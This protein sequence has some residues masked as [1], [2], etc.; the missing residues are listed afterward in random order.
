MVEN[1]QE[2]TIILI[3]VFIIIWCRIITIKIVIG[4][5]SHYILLELVLD[6]T[7]SVTHTDDDRV[8]AR[9]CVCDAQRG[10]ACQTNVVERWTV[11]RGIRVENRS[12]NCYRFCTLLS[13][14]VPH[15]GLLHLRSA[16]TSC[17]TPVLHIRSAPV[18]IRFA[19]SFCISAHY[20]FSGL[21][22]V[23]FIL[24][25]I[26]RIANFHLRSEK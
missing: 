2:L 5:S 11:W 12:A 21:F 13:T 10:R 18:H 1:W 23:F 22:Q 7:V 26:L 4:A 3:S 15:M 17:C 24:N 14:F 6:I 19:H 9:V 20:N 16:P 8:Y 25:F